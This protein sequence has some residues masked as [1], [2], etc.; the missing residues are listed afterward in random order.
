MMSLAAARTPSP[1]C[2]ATATAKSS[3]NLPFDRQA[4]LGAHSHLALERQLE[5]R[6]QNC[7]Q[8]VAQ[9]TSC[10]SFNFPFPALNSATPD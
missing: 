8:A 6:D 10:L 9:P 5:W 4:R 1:S 2:S 7:D 3:T